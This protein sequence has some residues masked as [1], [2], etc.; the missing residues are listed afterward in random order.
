MLEGRNSKGSRIPQVS[1][2]KGL[3]TFSAGQARSPQKILLPRCTE[4]PHHHSLRAEA[5]SSFIFLSA[6]YF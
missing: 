1:W 2:L 4:D 3:S 6:F 5:S